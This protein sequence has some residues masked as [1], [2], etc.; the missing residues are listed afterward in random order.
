MSMPIFEILSNLEFKYFFNLIVHST[1]N[2]QDAYFFIIDLQKV[3]EVINIFFFV[4]GK[5][6]SLRTSKTS[7]F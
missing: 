6:P 5:C 3:L 2:Q 1:F 7:F 4:L